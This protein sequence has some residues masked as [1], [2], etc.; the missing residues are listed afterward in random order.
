MFENIV[1]FILEFI[2][3]AADS[4]VYLYY[5][6]TF[7]APKL[8]CVSFNISAFIKQKI[9][10]GS[11]SNY[12]QVISDINVNESSTMAQKKKKSCL[13]ASRKLIKK[14]INEKHF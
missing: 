2:H 13:G 8:L 4:F 9:I 11:C 10:E 14:K 12:R 7:N 5:N 3:H 6:R 1:N